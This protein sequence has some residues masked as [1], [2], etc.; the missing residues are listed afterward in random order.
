MDGG[1]HGTGHL[2]ETNGTYYGRWRTSIGRNVNR[3]VGPVRPPGSR[4]G[5]TRAQA[6]REGRSVHAFPAGTDEA[7]AAWLL[8]VLDDSADR[9]VLVAMPVVESDAALDALEEEFRRAWNL[10]RSAGRDLGVGFLHAVEPRPGVQGFRTVAEVH[11][12]LVIGG[13]RLNGCGQQRA[14]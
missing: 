4:D 11:Q 6:G 13:E 3:K 5:L 10:A 2:Y 8:G 14:A 9:F 12:H 7:R 1:A